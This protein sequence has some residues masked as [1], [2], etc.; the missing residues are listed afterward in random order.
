MI[1]VVDACQSFGLQTTWFWPDRSVTTD[2][3]P[4]FVFPG[5]YMGPASIAL[6]ALKPETSFT[7][8]VLSGTA[9][10]LGDIA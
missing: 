8:L 1:P 4:V 10:V 3:T 7:V 6:S 9:F 2:S 5:L